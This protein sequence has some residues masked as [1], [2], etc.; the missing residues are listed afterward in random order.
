MKSI[1][2]IGTSVAIAV[3]YS[4]GGRLVMTKL[5]NIQVSVDVGVG[6]G[7]RGIFVPNQTTDVLRLC[8][9]LWQKLFSFKPWMNLVQKIAIMPLVPKGLN[10]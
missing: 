7:G 10:L 1:L 5:S 3:G 6:W 9:R 2:P 8:V 4:S